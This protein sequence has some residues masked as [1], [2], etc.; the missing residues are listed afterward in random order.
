MFQLKQQENADTIIGFS[1]KTIICLIIKTQ[2][3]DR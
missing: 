3:I 2:N 1:F